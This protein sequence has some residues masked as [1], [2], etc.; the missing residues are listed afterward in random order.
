MCIDFRKLND[1]QPEVHHADSQT[2]GNISLVSLP[3][4]DE[5]Y[6]RLK[7][8]KYFTT[9]DLQS[10]YYH[11]GLSGGSKAKTAF[12]TPFGKYQFEV[13]PFG[14]AQA[15]AYF[16]Q[17]ISM[18]LQDCSEFMM[19]YLDDIII[20]SRNECEHLNHI[21]IIISEIN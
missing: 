8:A 2:G 14:L 15:P 12:V 6:G 16:Q 20:F 7:G 21:Q 4:I 5:M 9:L 11:I 18:V 3:K 13:V 1:L 19:A 10:G 17:L